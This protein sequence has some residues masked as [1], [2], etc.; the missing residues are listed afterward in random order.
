MIKTRPAAAMAVVLAGAVFAS[1]GAQAQTKQVQAW[2]P[3][4]QEP[5]PAKRVPQA[6]EQ[7]GQQAPAAQQQA[8]PQPYVA[9]AS[10]GYEEGRGGFFLGVQA[11][12]GWVYEDVD[13]SARAVDAGYRWQAGPVALIGVEV[14][15]GRLDSTTDDGWRYG[16]VDYTSIGANARFNFGRTSPVYGL[17]RA[18]YWSADDDAGD[19]V[20]GGYFGLGLGVDVSRNF[21]LSLVYTNYVYF[22]DVEG[23]GVQYDDVNRADTLM[24]GAEVR[25]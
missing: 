10:E 20:D 15:R 14:A 13:Q 17:V 22:N 18:G 5:D 2:Q 6:Q 25:F 24:L 23:D 1:A 3:T 11:G 7:D 4:Q 8:Y 9:E 21:N 19:D 12:K 16:K